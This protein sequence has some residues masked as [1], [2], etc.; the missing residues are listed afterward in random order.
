MMQA[1]VNSE[2]HMSQA[3]QRDERLTAFLED[4]R[5]R[6]I[7]FCQRIVRDFH[8][9][10]DLYQE[11]CLRLQ[12][13]ELNFDKSRGDPV[14][15]LYKTLTNLSLNYRAKSERSNVSLEIHTN[16]K[17]ESVTLDVEKAGALTPEQ[18]CLQNES[19]ARLRMAL[20][21]LNEPQRQALV[22]K[23]V[24]NLSYKEIADE[25]KVSESNVGVL[26]LRAR[27]QLRKLLLS[28]LE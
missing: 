13:C 5:T 25:L 19:H 15:M 11:A 3:H 27:E 26:I 17:N 18:Q 9:A 20:L 21:T 12:T 10:E 28:S 8:A 6:G 14:A 16:S 23:D 24:K 1:R 7:S 2:F 4:H 22:M